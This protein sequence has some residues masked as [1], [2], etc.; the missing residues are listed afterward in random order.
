MGFI[1]NSLKNLAGDI[2]CAALTLDCDI[3]EKACD[4]YTG[5]TGTKTTPSYQSV[6]SSNTNTAVTDE[7][8]IKNED[9][10]TDNSDFASAVKNISK[11]IKGILSDNED[12]GKKPDDVSSE[13]VNTDSLAKELFSAVFGAVRSNGFNIDVSN[14][15]ANTVASMIIEGRSVGDISVSDIIGYC[16]SANI[17]DADIVYAVNTFATSNVENVIKDIEKSIQNNEVLSSAVK[18]AE[19]N[20]PKMKKPFTM[21]FSQF[22]QNN[23][24]TM[25]QLV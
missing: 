20:T 17:A 14:I 22:V 5:A 18:K 25:P 7:S 13:S 11:M 6:R 10:S 24:G 3:Q 15:L 1:F 23:K 19:D 12:N 9:T 2:Q 21:D 16:K 4:R 8:S